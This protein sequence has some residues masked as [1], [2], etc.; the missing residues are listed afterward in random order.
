MLKKLLQNRGAITRVNYLIINLI[1]YLIAPIGAIINNN[2]YFAC[3][4]ACTRGAHADAL[5]R[6]FRYLPWVMEMAC[7]RHGDNPYRGMGGISMGIRDNPYREVFVPNTEV[8]VRW[9]RA[10]GRNEHG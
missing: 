1:N 6:S 4:S 5:H 3:T 8:D 2:Y 10:E 9:L 7:I